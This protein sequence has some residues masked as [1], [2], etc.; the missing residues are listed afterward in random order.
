[1]AWQVCIRIP[2]VSDALELALP[3]G[4]ALK[5]ANLEQLLQPAI[6]PLGPAFKLVESVTA[7]AAVLLDLKDAVTS[8]PPDF[9]KAARALARVAEVPPNLAGLTPPLAVPLMAVGLIDIALRALGQAR[10]ELLQLQQ[11]ALGLGIVEQ[12]AQRL[13]DTRLLNVFE[14]CKANIEQE[15]ANLGQGMASVGHILGLISLLGSLAGL[16]L[17]VPNLESCSGRPL[18]EAVAH[19]H[20]LIETLIALR[21]AVPVA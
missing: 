10:S 13:E 7:I 2:T 20:A 3:G 8:V 1:M 11:Q 5:H 19:I 14:C 15:A 4:I 21:Q 12:T 9:S 16:N 18:N 17:S 6:A